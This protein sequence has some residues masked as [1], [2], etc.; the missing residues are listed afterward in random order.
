FGPKPGL[1]HLS[2][3]NIHYVARSIEYHSVQA[4]R[5]R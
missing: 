5:Y 4:P 2:I 3:R 1:Y